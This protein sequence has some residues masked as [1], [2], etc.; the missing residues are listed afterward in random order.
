MP[1]ECFKKVTPVCIF[2]TPQTP[3]KNFNKA[4]DIFLYE[5]VFIFLFSCL[6]LLLNDRYTSLFF[7]V[8][9]ASLTVAAILWVTGYTF[10]LF[11]KEEQ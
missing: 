1:V 9:I 6:L 7:K 10:D 4:F 2:I 5:G 3:M 8:S 11:A